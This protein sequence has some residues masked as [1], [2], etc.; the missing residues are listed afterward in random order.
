M[1]DMTTPYLFCSLL[2]KDINLQKSMFKPRFYLTESIQISYINIRSF[3]SIITQAFFVAIVYLLQFN[4]NYTEIKFIFTIAITDYIDI[5]F[6]Y[7]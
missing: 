5:F 4:S 1:L 2:I 6:V 7:R 3:L